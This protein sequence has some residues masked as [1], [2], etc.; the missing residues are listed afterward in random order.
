MTDKTL[1]YY[2]GCFDTLR[3]VF[4]WASFPDS[5]C[6]SNLRPKDI[7]VVGRALE[8]LKGLLSSQPD[9]VSAEGAKDLFLAVEEVALKAGYDVEEYLPH[10]EVELP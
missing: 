1:D 8:G 4:S 10:A 9:L 6:E 2:T 5:P 3:I 7:E